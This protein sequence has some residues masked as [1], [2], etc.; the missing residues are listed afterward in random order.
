MNKSELNSYKLD[1]NEDT[2]YDMILLN[3]THKEETENQDIYLNIDIF[4]K[5]FENVSSIID[6]IIE[7]S[8]NTYN[9]QR[10]DFDIAQSELI[11][12]FIKNK[13]VEIQYKFKSITNDQSFNVII[14]SILKDGYIYPISGMCIESESLYLDKSIAIIYN[15]ELISNKNDRMEVISNEKEIKE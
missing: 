15:L 12:R 1:I 8:N 13:E 2:L 14:T 4:Y 5:G 10:K 7:G 3:I 11:S 6:S 9:I